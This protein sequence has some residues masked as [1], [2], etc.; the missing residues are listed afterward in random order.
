M[1]SRRDEEWRRAAA[2]GVL[3]CRPA[4]SAPFCGSSSSTRSITLV[5][6]YNFAPYDLFDSHSAAGSCRRDRDERKAIIIQRSL[7]NIYLTIAQDFLYIYRLYGFMYENYRIAHRSALT[8]ILIHRYYRLILH[9]VKV[10]QLQLLQLYVANDV[11]I[12]IPS[13]YNIIPFIIII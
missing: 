13:T 12:N 1:A 9:Y 5:D 2:R 6:I 7:N 10:L 11:K 4:S 8:H 3:C